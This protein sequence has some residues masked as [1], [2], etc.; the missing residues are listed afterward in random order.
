[1]VLLTNLECIDFD[2]NDLSGS[3]PT[4]INELTSLEYFLAWNNV[5]TGPLPV[6]FSSFTLHIGLDDNMLTGPVPQSW[7]STM[8]ALT[9]VRVDK[10]YLTGTVPTTFGQLAYLKGLSVS[11]NLMTGTIPTAVLQLRS[12]EWLY[13]ANNSFTGAVCGLQEPSFYADADCEEV[14]CPCCMECC[15]DYIR[16]CTVLE[17]PTLPPSVDSM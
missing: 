6:S 17:E 10:N 2:W 9:N 15:Y 14:E 1:M 11:Y 16:S 5:L 4:R 8:P 13:L 12:L 7:G 3:I